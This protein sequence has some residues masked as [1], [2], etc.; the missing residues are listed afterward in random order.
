MSTLDKQAIID[1]ASEYVCP[2]RVK[3][4]RETGVEVVMARREGNFFYDV[5]GRQ[6]FDVHINGGTFSLGHRNPEILQT[7]R[8]ALD[9]Y[10]IGN[11]HFASEPRARAAE[12]I[13][14]LTPGDL[15]FTVFASGGSEATD[16]AIK[17]ARRATGRRK[18]VSIDCGYHGHTGL[19]MTVGDPTVARYFLS[20]G[21]ASDSVRVPFNDL[22]AVETA[23]SGDDVAAMIIETIPATAGFTL[24]AEGYLAGVK[25]LCESHGALYIAD[26]VQTG[27]GRTGRMWGVECYGVEPDILISAK[28]LSGGVYPIA[29]TVLSSRVADWLFENGWGHV[30]TFGG[31]EIGC[32][33]AMKTLEICSRPEVLENVATVSDYLGDA[34]QGLRQ[35]Y[36]FFKGLR[37]KGLVMGLE[38]DHEWGG[39]MMTGAGYECGLWA[40]FASFDRSV[41]QFKP[42][43]LI[44]KNECDDLLNRLEDSIKLAVSRI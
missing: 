40:F 28:G 36:P 33:V 13:A 43:I 18:I 11:H 32:R 9:A 19:S 21:P 10:D 14:A 16:I 12:M 27:L 35:R 41:L 38:F 1:L 31:S 34:M 24:P 37:R 30:S 17:T 15:K 22:G 2:G 29:A 3:T 7:V 25:R 5:D 23:L 42:S 8:E 44:T 39:T 20:D 26:E 6:L 4:F